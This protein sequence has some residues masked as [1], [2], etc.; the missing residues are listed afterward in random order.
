MVPF[1]SLD[2]VSYSPFTV[3]MALSCII[4]E[5]K[6]DIFSYSLAFDAPVMGDRRQNIAIPCGVERGATR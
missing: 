1:E 6:R 3:T 5:I 2:T 4:S